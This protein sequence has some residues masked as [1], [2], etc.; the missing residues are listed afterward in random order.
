MPAQETGT[1]VIFAP[2]LIFCF[3]AEAVKTHHALQ[4]IFVQINNA[5]LITTQNEVFYLG[6]F[7]W[8]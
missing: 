6:S 2:V 3:E 4:N 8:L 1:E 5:A 7:L